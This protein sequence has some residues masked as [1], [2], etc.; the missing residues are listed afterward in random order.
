QNVIISIVKPLIA[1]PP[2]VFPQDFYNTPVEGMRTYFATGYTVDM[3]IAT[4]QPPAWS[5]DEVPTIPSIV[6]AKRLDYG[7]LTGT[8]TQ[9][10]DDSE[11]ENVRV[12]ITPSD[13]GAYQTETALTDENGIYVIPA[14]LPGNYVAKFTKNGYNTVEMD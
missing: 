11:L 9:F 5:T 7:I 3:S 14:L 13:A 4:T 6:V 12:T 2:S 8:V 1:N 10:S